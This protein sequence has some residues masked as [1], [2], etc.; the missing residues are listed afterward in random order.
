MKA[1]ETM[2]LGKCRNEPMLHNLVDWMGEAGLPLV[3]DWVDHGG[4]RR[5]VGQFSDILAH[6]A[7]L[8]GF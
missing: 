5:R 8:N 6:A 1:L 4:A 2:L 3:K 7:D